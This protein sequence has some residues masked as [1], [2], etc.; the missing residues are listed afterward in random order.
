MNKLIT[1]IAG[2]TLGLFM[3]VGVGFG[4]GS[5]KEAVPVHA[6]EQITNTITF[7][8][9]KSNNNYSAPFTE[10]DDVSIDWTI[11]NF[12]NSNWQWN[13]KVD[14]ADKSIRC[15]IK[16]DTSVASIYNSAS[17]SNVTFT[18]VDLY[19]TAL[20]GDYFDNVTVYGGTSSEKI[21]TILASTTEVSAST[22]T[23]TILTFNNRSSY[24]YYKIAFSMKKGK[25]GALSLDKVCFYQDVQTTNPS[26]IFSNTTNV[27]GVGSS[28][29]NAASGDNLGE[30]SINYSSSDP[31]VVTVDPNTGEVTGVAFGSATITATANVSGKDYS[32]TYT[33]YVTSS[34]TTYYTVAQARAAINDGKG[35]TDQYVKG[36][37][38]QVDRFNSDYNSITYWISDDGS[39]SN[40]LQV[41]SGLGIGGDAFS[42]KE[43]V[44][45]GDIVV[46]KGELKHFGSTYEFDKNNELVSQISVASIAVKTAPTKTSYNGGE[47]FDPTGLVVTATYNNNPATTK[48][49]AYADLSTAFTFS[50][51]TS[52]ALTNQNEVTIS[53][54]GKSTTQSIIVTGRSITEITVTGTD[55]TNKTYVKDSPWNF[56]GLSLTVAYN[57]GNPTIFPLDTLTVGED[58]TID[59]QKADGATSLTIGGTYSGHSITSRTISGITYVSEVTFV[60]GTDKGSSGSSKADSM[61]KYG[62]TVAGTSMATTTAEYRIYANSTLTISSS[63]EKIRKIEF[64]DAGDPDKPASKIELISGKSGEYSNLVWLGNATSVSFSPSAQARVSKIAITTE[65]G[66]AAVNGLAVNGKTATI[67]QIFN[68]DVVKN[69]T[70][71][72]NVSVTP[73][74]ATESKEISYEV[75][76]GTGATVS[77][78]GLITGGAIV[79]DKATIKATSVANSD[80]YVYFNVTIID[81]NLKTVYDIDFKCSTGTNAF[82]VT[83]WESA[84]SES[85]AK[86]LTTG[87]IS[88]VFPYENAI[89]FGSSSAVGS[90]TLTTPDSVAIERVILRAKSYGTDDKPT[91]A[92]NDGE[93]QKP[94]ND[95]SYLIFDLDTALDKITISGTTGSKG[96]FYIN[97]I[98][99]IGKDNQAAVGAF[100]YAATFMNSLDKECSELA[101]TTTTWELLSSAWATMETSYSG[102]QAYFLAKTAASS[103]AQDETSNY[104]VIEKALARYDYIVGKYLKTLGLTAYNDFM[105]RN[106]S[107]VG[108]SKDILVMIN[109]NTDGVIPIIII[110]SLVSITAI[111]GYFFVRKNKEQ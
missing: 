66:Y 12:N 29:T 71:Q 89:R 11:A 2:A 48:E 41:Y 87:A 60:A 110:V 73:D 38:Y 51:K 27:V 64:V 94:S 95:W 65:S 30:V 3:A 45:V 76:S 52:E 56:T 25:N 5:S 69:K 61:L 90:I 47:Y 13:S 99:F 16:G 24:A 106:P 57:S 68:V 58:F 46:V 22:T 86:Y 39:S 75:T 83:T 54:F 44:K 103:A 93:P 79:G 40:P 67:G 55:M 85:D 35:L 104:D 6:V 50:P 42:S 1:K 59:H 32:D 21:E 81:S 74:N 18:K 78:T 19:I 31:N 28:V 62:I 96:R 43:D 10:S 23:P 107:T 4:V 101:V 77:K 102:S 70:E 14:G 63:G 91:I 49:F 98:Y 7:G 88:K 9:G 84:T 15:G 97:D 72:L 105:E 80:Y 8:N 111:G 34:S 37:V 20:T 82:S 100:G 36:V 26:V 33:I 108:N 109:G 17:L 92:V 53:L